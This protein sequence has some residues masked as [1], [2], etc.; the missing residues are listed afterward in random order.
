[1]LYCVTDIGSNTVKMNI[2]DRSDEGG[3]NLVYAVSSTLGLAGHRS[4]GALTD[5]GVELLTA[6]LLKYRKDAEAHGC[7]ELH[8]FATASLRN[9]SNT[10]QVCER[11]LRRTGMYIDVLSGEDEARMSFLGMKRELGDAEQGLTID[12]GGGSCELIRFE[13]SEPTD[14]VSIPLGCVLL[15]D[16]FIRSGR[17]PNADESRKIYSCVRD[18]VDACGILNRS[19]KHKPENGNMNGGDGFLVGGSARVLFRL[20]AADNSS[21]AIKNKETADF[22]EI[23]SERFPYRTGCNEPSRGM[24]TRA[25]FEQV[26]ESYA[27]AYR[28]ADTA[29]MI[30]LLVPDRLT[31]AVPGIIALRAIADAADLDTVHHCTSGVREGYLECLIETEKLSK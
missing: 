13:H 19:N 11:I 31:T 1:M 17:F 6:L 2:F 30:G 29:V 20:A 7:D 5:R 16:R 27:D 28:N 15:R 22:I 8:A 10:D 3:M 23:G 18:A 9:I 14:S 4:D 24:L 12:L 21:A 26:C 25:A